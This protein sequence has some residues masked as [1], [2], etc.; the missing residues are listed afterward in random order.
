[1]FGQVET[2][3]EVAA[4]TA[5]HNRAGRGRN[6]RK[7]GGDGGDGRIVERVA[8]FGAV[9]GEMDDGALV[10]DGQHIMGHRV[11]LSCW[12]ST[13]RTA[14]G[15]GMDFMLSGFS[16]SRPT[17]TRFSC[18]SMAICPPLTSVWRTEKLERPSAVISERISTRSPKREGFVNLAPV[19]TMGM[20][21][22]ACFSIQWRLCMPNAAE[23]S[24]AVA[25]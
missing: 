24:A 10:F 4:R 23:S 20:P 18:A 15:I 13:A 19:S 12:L 1:L 25:L 9:E 6:G 11:A 5:D 3:R 21:T 16:G 22:M 8:L 2:G 17:Q 7:E 14:S